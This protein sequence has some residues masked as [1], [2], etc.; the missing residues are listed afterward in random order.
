MYSFEQ[1]KLFVAV[2][3]CGSF[4]AAARKYRRAQSG[5][6]Q[7]VSN[8]EITFN[9]I[10]FDRSGNIPVLTPAGEALLP[11][12]KTILLQQQRLD[13]KLMALETAE[14]HE[15]VIAVEE[16]LLDNC[17]L[18]ELCALA[19]SHPMATINVV[20]ASTFDIKAM[21]SEGRAH[22]GVV[23]ADGTM[24]ED[25]EFKTIGYN[26]FVTLAAPTHPLASQKTV[27][28]TDLRN[29][30]Q[31]AHRSSVG[32]ELWFSYAISPQVW[33]AN[34]HQLMLEMAVNGLGWALVP[35]RLARSS[36]ER[37]ELQILNIAFEPDGWVTT[38][39]VVE[40]RRHQSG[41]V[42]QAAMEII[43]RAF[44]SYRFV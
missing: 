44:D 18:A 21:F 42:R 28:D 37:G 31:L 7:A 3:E 24:L 27:S 9:Q 1:L 38:V 13:Q 17:L 43:A 16:S 35:E 15:L 30:R 22:I 34:T 36:V 19:D 40:S 26:R 14:E 32:K 11:M 5:V 29:Y 39:D 2:C 8:L 6:S 4:S 25:A 10:L 23:Y 20:A 33:Y 12:A 41:P